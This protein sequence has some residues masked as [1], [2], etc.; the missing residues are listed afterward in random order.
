M[1]I[2]IKRWLNYSSWY[3]IN[4]CVIKLWIAKSLI[5]VLSNWTN[6]K[7]DIS[8]VLS[9]TEQSFIISDLCL[10]RLLYLFT[11]YVLEETKFVSWQIVNSIAQ[12]ILP[13][14]N[15]KSGRTELNKSE[16]CLKPGKSAKIE[17]SLSSLD[18]S[19]VANVWRILSCLSVYL[20]K[21][22]GCYSLTA[23]ACSIVHRYTMDISLR[24]IYPTSWGLL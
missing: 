21:A 5:V 20:F 9:D 1:Y 22:I 19:H 8:H 7:T 2:Y 16:V 10:S 24:K 15:A 4:E 12:T 11:L 23:H 14:F 18:C 17:L 13:F 6:P 3:T